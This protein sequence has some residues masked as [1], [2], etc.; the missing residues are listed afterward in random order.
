MGCAGHVGDRD[1]DPEDQGDPGLDSGGPDPQHASGSL[2]APGSAALGL[3]SACDLPPSGPFA[4]GRF[5]T[6]FG[7]YFD[8]ADTYTIVIRILVGKNFSASARLWA[9][10]P[11]PLL[12]LMTRSICLMPSDQ[13]MASFCQ[14]DFIETSFSYT[15]F[16]R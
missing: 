3:G 1:R 15:P 14:K 9:W 6:L 5:G 4:A 2:I 13:T 7:S 11:P 10:P 8:P 12:S 16:S